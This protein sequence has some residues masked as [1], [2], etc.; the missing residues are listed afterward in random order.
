MVVCKVH[1]RRMTSRGL[2]ATR[3]ASAVSPSG[4]VPNLAGVQEHQ[5]PRISSLVFFLQRH[6]RR[7]RL[8]ATDAYLLLFS[9]FLRRV[10]DL[11]V[12]Q[13]AAILP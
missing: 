5:K 13:S 8:F 10:T 11:L 9:P 2:S 4:V 1:T 3:P 6:C 12:Q 7:L